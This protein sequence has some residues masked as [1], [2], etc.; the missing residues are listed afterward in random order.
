MTQR[1]T[2]DVELALLTGDLG[3]I[4]TAFAR[5]FGRVGAYRASLREKDSDQDPIGD[6]RALAGQKAYE[7]LGKLLAH[8]PLASEGARRA[9]AALTLFRIGAPLERAVFLELGKPRD[10]AFPSGGQS[11]FAAS[12][13]ALACERE[14]RARAA[15]LDLLVSAAPDVSAPQRE[16]SSVRREIC[17]R[18]GVAHPL[19]YAAES[20]VEE[21]RSVAE[22]LLSRTNRLFQDIVAR[23]KKILA[24][25]RWTPLSGVDLARVDTAVHGWPARVSREWLA[26]AVPALR[27]RASAPARSHRLVGASSFSRVL[28]AYGVELRRGSAPRSL[29]FYVAQDPWPRAAY[30]LGYLLAALPCSAAFQRRS[31]GLSPGPATDQALALAAG[32]VLSMRWLCARVLLALSDPSAER[33]TEL[34]LA[35]FGAPFAE[36]LGGGWPTPRLSDGA[37]LLAAVDSHAWSV[38]MVRRFDDDWFGNPRAGKDIQSRITGPMRDMPDTPDTS[39]GPAPIARRVEELARAL[40]APFG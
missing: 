28:Y 19:A 25:K 6:A 27:E 29:P 31:L 35:A 38:E 34:T 2:P 14:P 33:F 20:S 37:R 22:T 4:S 12:V 24:D 11:S 10:L 23:Q 9:T 40:E 15:H 39:S 7:A 17:A 36:R 26:E 3:S 30:Q 21:L 8:D 1:G 13:A 32:A 5:A 18:L 16:L